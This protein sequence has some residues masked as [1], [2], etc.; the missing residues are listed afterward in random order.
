MDQ[1]YS[2]MKTIEN[3]LYTNPVNSP[4]PAVET[5]VYTGNKVKM[6]RGFIIRMAA[7]S[8]YEK[9]NNLNL[10]DFFRQYVCTTNATIQNSIIQFSI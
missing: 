8:W 6:E 5:E 1:D 4:L 7:N 9:N 10:I 3:K 2:I